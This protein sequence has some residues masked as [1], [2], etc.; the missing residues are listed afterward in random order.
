MALQI[1]PTRSQV[2]LMNDQVPDWITA[3]A[4]R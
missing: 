4:V 2:K 1:I 3:L